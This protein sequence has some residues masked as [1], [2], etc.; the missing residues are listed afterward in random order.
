MKGGERGVETVIAA[1]LTSAVVSAVISKLIA[2]YHFK[3][4]DSYVKSMV[5]LA[6][7]YMQ[8]V[9]NHLDRLK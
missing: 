3:V 6:K 4:I 2:A 9:G 5:D 1:V 8:K 7:S